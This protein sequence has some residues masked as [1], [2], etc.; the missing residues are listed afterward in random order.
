MVGAPA[1]DIE[2]VRVATRRLLRTVADL[3]DEQAGAASPLSGW[4]PRELLTHVA[5][6]ADGGA[7]IAH[8]AARGEIGRQYPGGQ[9]QRAEGIAA[10]R[11]APAAALVADLRRSCDALMES[12][13]QLPDDG[14]DRPGLSLT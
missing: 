3:T 8:A 1:T 13:Q 4:S 6:N 11:G 14:W 12:W 7:G 9:H 5:R 2:A 10:G